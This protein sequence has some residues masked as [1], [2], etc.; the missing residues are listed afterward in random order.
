LAHEESWYYVAASVLC[1]WS[2]ISLFWIQT[3]GAILTPL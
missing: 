1:V 3:T 2:H